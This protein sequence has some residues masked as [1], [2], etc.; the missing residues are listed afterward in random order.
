[1]QPVESTTEKPT[2]GEVTS[3]RAAVP[4][5][6]PFA[7]FIGFMALDRVTGAGATLYPVRV[8]VV[9]TLLILFSRRVMPVKPSCFAP[10]V[11]MGLVVYVIWVGPDVLWPAYRTH[12]LF[13]NPL[14]GTASSSLPPGVKTDPVFIFF[15]T[16]GCV[17]LVPFVEE[18]FWRG[19]LSRWLINPHFQKVSLGA[20]TAASFWISALLFASE[21]GPYWEVGL[22]AGIAYN[23]WLMRTRNLADCVLAHAVTNGC[24]AVHVLVTDQWQYWM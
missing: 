14:M 21:H 4:Y 3:W 12:W 17:A 18:L 13:Q 10:S 1:M 22:V 6:L 15:R 16:V 20:F 9:A 8:V 11:A 5:V 7:A 23:W 2:G 19:W 24:L